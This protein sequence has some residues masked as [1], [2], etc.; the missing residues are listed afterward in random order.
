MCDKKNKVLFT[1]TECLVLSSDFKLPDENQVLL[2]IPRQN[3]MYSFNLENIVPSGCLACLIAKAIVDESNK[4]HRRLG[5]VNFKNLNKLVKGNLVRG[6]PSKIFQN[7]HTCVACQKGKQHKASIPNDI[8]NSV[9]ACKTAKQIWE[10]IKRLMHGSEKTEQQRHSRLVDEFDKFVTV[11]GE[12]LSFVYERL[13][14]LVNVMEQNNIHPLS[15]SINTKFLNSLQPEWSK[16]VTMTRQIANIKETE[17]DNLFDTLIQYEPHVIASRAKKAARNHDPLGL[18]AHLNVHS[19]HSHVSPSYSHSL[20]PYYVTH[21]SSV[22]DYEEDYQREKQGDAQED[23][24]TT[25]MMLLARA[26]TQCYSTLTN[27]RLRTSSNTW[28]QAVIQDGRV[29]I[30]R[31]NVGYAGNG[32]GTQGNQIEIKFLLQGMGCIT[33]RNFH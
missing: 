2:R 16:Y 19:L 6:L 18:V 12:S 17:F 25:A 8:Y 15:I 28:N 1:N 31:K 26:I 27:N 14:T 22:I 3:N 24:L 11:E 29:D 21:P 33:T 4:W 32:N 9:D 7:D 13:T 30:Q 20:Q 23:K 5:H 10:R